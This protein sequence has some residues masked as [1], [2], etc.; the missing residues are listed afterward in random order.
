MKKKKILTPNLKPGM[1]TAEEVYD[2]SNRLIISTNTALDDDII[3]KLKYYS[4][5][6]VKIFIPEEN[7]TDNQPQKE[8]EHTTYFEKTQA[9]ETFQ[10]F[11]KE[12]NN[13]INVFKAALDDFVVQ[14]SSDIIDDMVIH[15]YDLATKSRN[16]LHLLDM[17]QCIQGYDD[18]TYAHSINVA[19]ICNIIGTWLHLSNNELTVLISAG[20]LHDIGKLKIPLEILTKPG[21]LT[22]EEFKLMKKHSKYGYDILKT[23]PLDARIALAALQHHE[24]YD[25]SGYP[26]GLSGDEI[27]LFSSIVTIA[28]VYEAMTADRYY[29]KGICPFPVL[30]ALEKEKNHYEPSVLHTFINRTVEAYI[31]SEVQLSN[32]ELGK[33]VLINQNFLSRPVVVT[34]DKTYDLSKDSS[35]QITTLL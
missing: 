22:D 21:K 7:D 19:L 35:I 10:V 29:R 12:Y 28:D 3:A 18:T 5:K 23:K 13:S 32:G 34:N 25:G 33:V 11:S 14:N 1:I 27:E 15:V 30:E 8:S 9:S 17:M 6:A 24:R 4:V 16:P 20:L 31:N 26:Y 2:F